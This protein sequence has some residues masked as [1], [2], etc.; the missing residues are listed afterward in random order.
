MSYFSKEEIIDELKGEGVSVSYAPQIMK[1][2]RINK[3]FFDGEKAEKIIK[4]LKA[5]N[6]IYDKYKPKTIFDD[7][8]LTPNE[9]TA[10]IDYQLRYI[11]DKYTP[12]GLEL[13]FPSLEESHKWLRKES[14]EGVLSIDRIQCPALTHKDSGVSKSSLITMPYRRLDNKGVKVKDEII[15][16]YSPFLLELNSTIISLKNSTGV[17]GIEIL[18][19]LLCGN[20]IEFSRIKGTIAADAFNQYFIIQINTNDLTKKEWD[21]IYSVYRENSNRKHKKKL[22]NDNIKLDKILKKIEVPEKPN[23]EF[24]RNLIKFWNEETGDNMDINNWRTMRRRFEI[25][26]ERKEEISPF[27]QSIIEILNDYKK[28]EV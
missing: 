28:E 6:K 7:T 21:E 2:C 20:D 26:K 17:D 9:L 18:N 27:N 15:C 16:N 8:Y 25:L 22:S 24:F 11:K 4:N 10:Y 3:E 12:F 1:A 13:P 5:A 19:Y 23:A 14:S